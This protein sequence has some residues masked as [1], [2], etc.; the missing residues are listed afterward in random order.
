MKTKLSLIALFTCALIIFNGCKKDTPGPSLTS[1][2][3]TFSNWTWDGN[4]NYKYDYV[5]LTWDGLTSDIVDNGAVNMY[6]QTPSGWAPLPRTIA[7]SGTLYDYAQCQRYTYD[8]GRFKIIVQDDD[9]AE[10]DPLG[11]WTIKIVAISNSQRKANP[12]LDWND[13]PAVK[14]RFNLAD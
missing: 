9:L 1:K 8:V 7:L 12:D 5:D 11:N 4:T 3:F 2:T 6:L 14:K 10:P 13:Y